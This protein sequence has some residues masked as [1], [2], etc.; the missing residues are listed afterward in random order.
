M[1][2]AALLRQGSRNSLETELR[3]VARP[4]GAVHVYGVVGGVG[5]VPEVLAEVGDLLCPGGV[6][7]DYDDSRVVVA[8][9][10][11]ENVHCTVGTSPDLDSRRSQSGDVA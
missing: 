5:P 1:L 8:I 6:N 9:A 10:L 4:V 3:Q 7:A 11:I 2:T